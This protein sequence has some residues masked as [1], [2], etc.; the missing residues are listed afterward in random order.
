MVTEYYWPFDLGGSEWSTYYLAKGLIDAGHQVLVLTPNYGSNQSEVK[1]KINISR[2]PFPKKIK[3]N[4]PLSPFWHTNILWILLTTY[5]LIKICKKEKVDV[6]HLQGKYYSPA[7]FFIKKFLG[8]PAILTA[9]D[10]Q[11][12]CNYGFC[13][14][15]KSKSCNLKSY[16][17]DD[18]AKYYQTYVRNKN[19]VTLLINL[20][21]ALRAR[22]IRNIYKY[23]AMRLDKVICISNAQAEIYRS[24]DFK[25]VDV[26]YNSS[27]FRIGRSQPQ[28]KI[29]YAGRLTPGKGVDLLLKAVPS[30]FKKFPKLKLMIFG[31]GFLRRNLEKTLNVDLK[32]RILFKGQVSHTALLGEY[33]GSLAV[34]MPSIWP[35]PFGRV[36]LESISQGT[37][38]VAT[39]SGGLPEIVENGRT[40]IL[41]EPSA[42]ELSKSIIKIVENNSS[43]R[44]EIRKKLPLLRNKF[45]DN[46][47]KQYLKVYKSF[48]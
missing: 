16:F 35:E 43:F 20:I 1:D 11:L 19:T 45:Q 6:V 17:T 12:I 33:A 40:G 5:Y 9:R 13:I 44:L 41:C 27:E 8:I 25:K 39:K 24:N 26:I 28:N 4:R 32:G 31:E 36:A 3:N 7:G 21:F 23:F 18:F 47:I 42:S 22:V 37:P 14:W 30:V 48:L 38:V 34:V 15:Q 29:V 46:T 10:Y 2:F